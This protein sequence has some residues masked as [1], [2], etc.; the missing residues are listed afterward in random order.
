VLVEVKAVQKDSGSGYYLAVVKVA[1][2]ENMK[3]E[4]KAANLAAQ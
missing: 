3:A 1:W 4:M 2:L